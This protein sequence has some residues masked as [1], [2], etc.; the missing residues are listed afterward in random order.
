[1]IPLTGLPVE[2]SVAALRTALAQDGQAVLQ[3]PPGAGKTTVVPLRV[4]EEPW[5]AGGRMDV[6]FKLEENTWN[7]RTSI[8][9]K[10]VDL[11]PAE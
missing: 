6:A 2:E 1:M 5:L 8:Q 10:I 3:A 11:R 7:G 9:A 4:L